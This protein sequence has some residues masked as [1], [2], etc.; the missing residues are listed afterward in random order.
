LR[1]ENGRLRLN[2]NRERVQL[3]LDVLAQVAPHLPEIE[4]VSHLAR[5]LPAL[6]TILHSDLE[7]SDAHE[8]IDTDIV[9]GGFDAEKATV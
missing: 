5:L 6:D 7:I 1:L 2:L 4:K 3:A 8:M 9:E